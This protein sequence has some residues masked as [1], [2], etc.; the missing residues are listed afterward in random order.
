MGDFDDGG[1]NMN[2][3]IFV[4][5]GVDGKVVVFLIF[6]DDWVFFIGVLGYNY[7]KIKE[8]YGLIK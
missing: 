7:I 1:Y 2:M 8:V 5:V 6:C 3:L 4:Y